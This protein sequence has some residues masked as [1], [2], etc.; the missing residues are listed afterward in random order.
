MKT[1]KLLIVTLVT[2]ITIQSVHAQSDK[3]QRAIGVKTQTVKAYGTCDM[4][5]RRIEKAALTVAG[6]K[7][8]NWDI[9]TQ[10]LTVKYDLFKKDAVDNV[11]KKIASVGNDTEKYRADDMAYQKLPDCCHYQR[12]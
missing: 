2:L 7:F 12:K 8:V 11:Q 9:D 3:Y 5:R 10:S 1:F 6:V 4:D